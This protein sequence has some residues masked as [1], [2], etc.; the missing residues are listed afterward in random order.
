MKLSKSKYE[1]L[2]A[3]TKIIGLVLLAFS[4]DRVT[5]GNYSVALALFGLGA[6]ISIIPLYIE[7][8]PSA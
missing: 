6:L 7:V 1:K 3:V 2:D 8:E 5:K 4:I